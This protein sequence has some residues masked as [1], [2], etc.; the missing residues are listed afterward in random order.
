MFFSTNSV[1]CYTNAQK[2][3]F[4][5]T[6]LLSSISCAKLTYLLLSSHK[7]LNADEITNS[8]RLV[9]FLALSYNRIWNR[10][11]PT[12]VQLPATVSRNNMSI[13]HI[14][15]CFI[16]FNHFHFNTVSWC[17]IFT[18]FVCLLHNPCSLMWNI[19]TNWGVIFFFRN[20]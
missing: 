5:S 9:S 20:W 18:T 7:F 12:S 2:I 14:M 17:S 1:G 6:L 3:I 19:L 13:S 11:S 4:F 10:Y 16:S 8:V 15:M